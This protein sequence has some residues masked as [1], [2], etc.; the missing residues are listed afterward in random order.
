MLLG[1]VRPSAG[2]AEVLGRAPGDPA[3]LARMGAMME[4]PAFYPYQGSIEPGQDGG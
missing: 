4:T 1:L 2:G 3:G